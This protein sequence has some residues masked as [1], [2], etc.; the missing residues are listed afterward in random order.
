MGYRWNINV[1]MYDVNNVCVYMVVTCCIYIY[2]ISYYMYSIICAEQLN[3]HF[4]WGRTMIKKNMCDI[5]QQVYVY[6]AGKSIVGLPSDNFSGGI[7]QDL[8]H[9]K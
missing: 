4:Q 6:I 1:F 5:K 8:R 9:R 3:N 7:L 2:I